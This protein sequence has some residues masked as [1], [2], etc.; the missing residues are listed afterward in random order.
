[1]DSITKKEME[2]VR[3]PIQ[4]PISIKQNFLISPDKSKKE[5][6]KSI[7]TFFESF[8]SGMNEATTRERA[9]YLGR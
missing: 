8:F 3:N 4:E 5:K 7:F 6:K 9:H 1:M 2:T